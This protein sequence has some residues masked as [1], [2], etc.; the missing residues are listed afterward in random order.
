MAAALNLPAD[1]ITSVAAATVAQEFVAAPGATETNTVTLGFAVAADAYDPAATSGAASPAGYAAALAAKM[2][3]LPADVTV[4]AV[5]NAD[6]TYS[7]T[8]VV[9]AGDDAAA[10]EALAAQAST[11]TPPE[12]ATALNLPADAIAS[13]APPTV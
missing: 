12:M 5:R 7:V 2:G 10:A 6:G 3:V 8:A 1:A 13:V 4:T 9:D 11:I